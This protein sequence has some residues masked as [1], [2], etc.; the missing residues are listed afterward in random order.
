[1]KEDAFSLRWIPAFAGI[2]GGDANGCALILPCDAREA[3]GP[4]TAGVSRRIHPRPGMRTGGLVEAQEQRVDAGADAA[5]D[6]PGHGR[7]AQ[8]GVKQSSEPARE[9]AGMGRG[10]GED[11]GETRR[12]LHQ[13]GPLQR[14]RVFAH[15]AA[16]GA[17]GTFDEREERRAAAPSCGGRL[18]IIFRRRRSDAR[19]RKDKLRRED[20]DI[21]ADQRRNRDQLRPPPSRWRRRPPA[22]W[23]AAA[24]AARTAA[25]RWDTRIRDAGGSSAEHNPTRNA[26]GFAGADIF[27]RRCSGGPLFSGRVPNWSRTAVTIRRSQPT[28]IRR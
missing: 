15:A 5:D 23:R 18:W 12:S 1:M 8:A 6:V 16:T 25:G 19:Q 9:A 21:A 14:R 22:P 20:V 28:A 7:L 24:R 17:G 4:Q 10:I 13:Q 3:F 26:V 27:T 2:C 11:A